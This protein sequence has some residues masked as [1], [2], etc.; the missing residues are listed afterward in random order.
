MKLNS[1]V[2]YLRYRLDTDSAFGMIFYPTP[3]YKFTASDDILLEESI[4]YKHNENWEF[5]GGFS[6]LYAG[7]M[8]KTND[9]IK[10]YDKFLY[11]AFRLDIPEQGIYQSPLLGNFGFNPLTYSNL[12][13][14][15]QTTYSNERLTLLLGV[16]YDRHSEYKSKT[17]PRIAGIFNITENGRRR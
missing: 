6:Y 2:S 14:F 10:P 4:I 12:A 8:P 15:L 9:L 16:R 3:L 13:G 5:V 17:N 1:F 7:A 11:K